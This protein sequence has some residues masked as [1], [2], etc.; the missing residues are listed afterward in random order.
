MP[1]LLLILLAGCGTDSCLLGI[2]AGSG[3]RVRA[4]RLPEPVRSG[5]PEAPFG[6]E[7]ACAR[8]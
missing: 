6:A 5:T 1:T 4:V 3:H 2:P 8:R 7:A